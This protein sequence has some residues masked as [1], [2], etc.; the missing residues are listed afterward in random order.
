MTS[1]AT[2]VTLM[3]LRNGVLVAA[4]LIA[5][6]RLWRQTVLGAARGGDESADR[7]VPAGAEGP[8]RAGSAATPARAR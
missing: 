8:N 7:P 3:L 4:T 1:D 6:R 2:G 5:C